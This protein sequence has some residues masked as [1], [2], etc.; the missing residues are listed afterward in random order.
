MLVQVPY[1]KAVTAQC[2]CCC[3]LHSCWSCLCN[4]RNSPD[5]E[6]RCVH[7]LLRMLHVHLADACSP[8]SR[9]GLMEATNNKKTAHQAHCQCPHFNKEEAASRRRG[10]LV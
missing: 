9:K 2:A 10:Q 5:S 7:T 4:P 1:T 3:Q 6:R 8:A